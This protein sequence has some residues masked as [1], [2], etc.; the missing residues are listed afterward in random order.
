M[1][2]V[3]WLAMVVLG[4]SCKTPGESTSPDDANTIGG[5][6][7]DPTKPDGASTGVDPD[8][9]AKKAAAQKV[10]AKVRDRDP[11]EEKRKL[12][13]SKQRS[14]QA[15]KMLE[16]G[17][18]EE[19][20]ANARASLKIHE[21]NVDAML[22][23]AEVYYREKKYELTVSVTGTA[24]AV[25]E[26]I[27]TPKET[28]IAYNLQGFAFAS[29]GQNQRATKA[30]KLAAEADDKNAAA[31][32]NLGTRY[33]RGG[34]VKT[35]A[36]CFA[37]AIELEPGFA[38]AHLN[39]GAALR[40][41]RK[42]I[43]AEKEFLQALK[44][45]KTYPEAYFNLGLLYL[46]ADP[47]PKLD[48]VQRLNK[49]ILYLEKYKGMATDFSTEP[50]PKGV[51]NKKDLAPVSRARAEDYIRVAQKGLDREARR[52]KREAERSTK[53][54]KEVKEDTGG[55]GT[56]AE[57]EV[58]PDEA[59]AAKADAPTKPGAGEPVKPGSTTPVKPGSTTPVKPGSSTP[60]KPGANA[61]T[62]PSTT[63]PTKPGA[64]T[65]TQPA[66]T[67]SAPTKPGT[68][69]PPKP[70]ANTPTQ[71]T[72]PTQP[73]KTAPTKTAPTK[74][75][76]SSPTPP[77]QPSAP[78]K[79]GATA[80]VKPSAPTT[81]PKSP[82]PTA[83]QKPGV[84]KPGQKSASAWNPRRNADTN[85]NG[86][87]LSRHPYARAWLPNVQPWSQRAPQPRAGGRDLL[88]EELA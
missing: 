71:P 19:A 24:L 33:L 46:D 79:P 76:P 81:A 13:Q 63:T 86:A 43:E 61:P 80:P 2:R 18:F 15:R 35:A 17:R 27:R 5:L 45:K 78:Q 32:N 49:A 10:L 6:E 41:Q 88:A 12:A 84:Q 38:K 87:G 42:W 64:S 83:P 85:Q 53:G 57:G 34:D 21:Q 51:G 59:G 39:Y 36:Q 22:V 68:T 75:A 55:A 65:P 62:Q 82:S 47:F 4:L 54:A 70:G 37:Y 23:L 30:F 16:G 44:I 69:T 14:A 9:A 29:M 58:P 72:T 20:V 73:S 60:A 48:T 11:E 8:E 31:W 56:G 74:T 25:D 52:T 66:P 1:K 67:P 40:G 3:L 28:S 50:V 7:K 77:T 26:K